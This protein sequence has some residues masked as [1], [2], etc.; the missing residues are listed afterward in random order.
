MEYSAP[1]KRILD[2]ALSVIARHTISGTRMHLIA[3]EAGMSSANL[4]YHF[5]TKDELLL[6][7]LEDLQQTFAEKRNAVLAQCEDTLEGHLRAFFQQKR[8]LIYDSPQYDQ[9]QF[10]FWVM[11]QSD[12]K[13]NRLFRNSFGEWRN[14]LSN[15]ILRFRPAIAPS[16]VDLISHS[17]ISMMMGGSM[18]YIN[19]NGFDLDSYFELCLKETLL[20]IDACC[21]GH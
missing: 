1:E 18:Q 19:G 14:H 5:K 10:D 3:Q 20:C 11:G 17:I 16:C 12:E 6:A 8:D 4:H 9:V 15:S 7:L 2:A 21:S 13:M